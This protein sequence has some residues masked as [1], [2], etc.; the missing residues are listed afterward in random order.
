MVMKTWL[1]PLLLLG[2]LAVP[3][4]AETP[5]DNRLRLPPDIL[6]DLRRAE[7]AMKRGLETMR[8]S[9][10]LLLRAVPQY[11]MPRLNEEGD[12]IIKRR[13]PEENRGIAPRR[14]NDTI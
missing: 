3:A 12:I 2:A 11:E 9:V 8:E 4:A 13:K 6:E 10:D 1:L 5:S 7:E 14:S